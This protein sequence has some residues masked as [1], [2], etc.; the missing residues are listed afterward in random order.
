MK[1]LEFILILQGIQKAV[2]SNAFI[3]RYVVE[4][5]VVENFSGSINE[6]EA[7]FHQKNTEFTEKRIG[8]SKLL[9]QHI[10]YLE[11]EIE[12]FQEKYTISESL[13]LKG[14][15]AG[16]YADLVKQ[17]EKLCKIEAIHL[18]DLLKMSELLE[19][20]VIQD[21]KKYRFNESR[22][23]RGKIFYKDITE[24]TQD[25]LSLFKDEYTKELLGEDFY[26]KTRVF[27]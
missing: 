14:R 11:N 18:D 27:T 7:Q 10:G 4:N 5:M 19:Y 13:E 16:L 20:R 25:F 2:G 3:K 24:E 1:T 22:H 12:T 8:A 9:V 26:K 6:L 23:S 21:G 15:I 17:K